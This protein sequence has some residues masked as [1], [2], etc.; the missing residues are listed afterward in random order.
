MDLGLVSCT[1][2]KRIH[3]CRAREMYSVS[4]LFRKA[5]SYAT[6]N[7]D[8]VGILSAKYGFLLPDDIIEPYE[9]TLKKMERRQRLEWAD[10]VFRQL[11]ERLELNGIERA[12]FHVGKEYREFLI[13]KMEGIGI[14]CFVPLE[15]LSFGRQLAW[16][17]RQG[18]R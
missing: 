18:A 14:G 15:G 9:L 1:K 3:R 4:V 10:R 8:L 13:P 16:Y 12:F 6:E 11:Q 17:K 2:S 7:Y 5:F